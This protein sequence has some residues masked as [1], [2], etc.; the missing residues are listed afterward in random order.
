MSKKSKAE[1]LLVFQ[2]KAVGLPEP[3]REHRFHAKRQ[4]RFD[5]AYP[6]LK[7]AVEVHGGVWSQGRH[8]RG[9]GF[10][11]DCEKYSHAAIDGWLIVHATTAQVTAGLALQWI[12]AALQ[13]KTLA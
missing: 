10:T 9:Q 13:N 1:A 2:T 7:I 12:E 8:T 11:D 6:D 5:I 4:W 3:T